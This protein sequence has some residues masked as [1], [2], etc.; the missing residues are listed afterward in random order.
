MSEAIEKSLQKLLREVP[1]VS[2]IG[3]GPVPLPSPSGEMRDHLFVN[4]TF[5]DLDCGGDATGLVER[6]R[7]LAFESF[8]R[9]HRGANV[10][11]YATICLSLFTP[12]SETEGIRIYRTRLKTTDLPRLSRD[13]LQELVTGEESGRPDLHRQL[14]SSR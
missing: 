8:L 3:G 9:L 5:S 14:Q 11:G 6:L 4:L 1:G 7:D 2:K 10:R 12:I 13:K